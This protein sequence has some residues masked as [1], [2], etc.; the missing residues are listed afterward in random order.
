[1]QYCKSGTKLSY[2]APSGIDFDL[3]IF[4]FGQGLEVHMQGTHTYVIGLL[5]FM[6]FD[7]VNA[8]CMTISFRAAAVEAWSSAGIDK[9]DPICV[10]SV[11]LYTNKISL[12][13]LNMSTS[14]NNL[15]PFS[16]CLG[17]LGTFVESTREHIFHF[18]K[19]TICEGLFL[20]LDPSFVY[21]NSSPS[22]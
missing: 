4:V 12:S 18:S 15:K 16:I 22:Y 7:V 19:V 3:G 10:R 13:N 14:M 9:V 1:M 20:Y 6:L 2:E 17:L 21:H 11:R 5:K 8:F